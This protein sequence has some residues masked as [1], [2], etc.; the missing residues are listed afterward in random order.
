MT[1][2]ERVRTG[3]ATAVD[4]APGH[5]SD[6]G[7]I[8]REGVKRRNRKRLF[9]IGAVLAGTIA[10]TSPQLFGFTLGSEEVSV[11]VAGREMPY[12][13]VLNENPTVVR[14]VEVEA[15]RFDT[16]HLGREI[17]FGASDLPT[18]IPDS[19]SDGGV[20]AGTVEGIPVFVYGDRVVSEEVFCV[21]TGGDSICTDAAAPGGST[22][23]SSEFGPT[24][25]VIIGSMTGDLPA[26]V[27]VVAYSYTETGEVI[28]WQIPVA[29]VSYIPIGERSDEHPR[30][31]LEF[32]DAN[33]QLLDT[34]E[35]LG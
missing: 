6:V 34:Y 27:S 14:G 23:F 26:E 31:T 1:F 17:P 3:I 30:I 24:G 4:A 32:Y 25:D 20:F 12:S 35:S 19:L 5:V 8:T 9:G 16:S 13:E 18:E 15:P 29:Y 22:S 33:G 2:E 21:T 28:G 10:M 7:V 11:T